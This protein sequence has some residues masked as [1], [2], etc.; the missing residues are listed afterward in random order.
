MFRTQANPMDDAI[1]KATDENL[2]NENWEFIL[3]V[4][5][6]VSASPSGPQQAVASLIKRLAHRNANVQLYTLELANAL[7]QNCGAPLHRELASRAFTEALLRL[8]GDRNTHA[9]VKQKVMERMETWTEEFGNSPDFGIMGDAYRKL[10]TT[11]PSLQP[12][13][14]PGK[15]EISTE[16]R[17]KEEDELQMALALSV[18][19]NTKPKANG[20][21]REDSDPPAQA[22]AGAPQAQGTTAATVSRVRA[23]YDFTPSEAGELA[24]RKNDIIAVLESVYKDW[25]KGSLRGQTGIFPLN[26]VEKLQDPTKDELERD[27]QMEAEVFGE[28]KNVERL[29]AL[30][31]VQTEGGVGRRGEREE[32]EISELYQRTLSIRPK[33]IELIGKYSQKKDDFTQ[34]NEKFIKARRDYEALLESSMAQPQHYQQYPSRARPGQM[35]PQAGQQPYAQPGHSANYAQG[36]PVGYAAPQQYA[37]QGHMP[38]Q[39]Q[40]LQ[41]DPAQ[42]F[43]SPAPQQ[44]Q[45]QEPT[46]HAGYAVSPYPGQPGGAP[47]SAGP[48]AFHFIPGGVGPPDPASSAVRRKPSPQSSAQQVPSAPPSE[49][50][51][52]AGGAPYWRIRVADRQSKVLSPAAALAQQAP[53]QAYDNYPPGQAQQV[54]PQGSTYPPY[55]YSQTSQSMHPQHSGQAPQAVHPQQHGGQVQ[56][57]PASLQPQAQRTDLNSLPSR[58]RTQSFESSYSSVG[59]DPTNFA[60]SLQHAP[61]PAQ[62]VGAPPGIPSSPPMQNPGFQQY[63]AYNPQRAPA[64]VA[65]SDDPGDFYR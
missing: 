5:D 54:A 47:P 6:R 65:A 45:Q 22:S 48:A 50:G 52:L 32:E 55:Q 34:L 27:A 8:A 43:Y 20:T 31:S 51:G 60:A 13:S 62:P 53:Q 19:D 3:D 2:V 58:Q 37:T 39:Q 44:Q 26:Y 38:P 1:V 35:Y 15:R 36:P 29:L 57:Q 33:L 12:P 40:P 25:W 7:S 11:Q 10:R 16:D 61:P 24:F 56:A 64:A 63:Q 9:Q 59:P 23:L 49:M 4:C 14:K 46:Q 28:I 17:K 21:V 30:L 41:Q 18:Q 42:R